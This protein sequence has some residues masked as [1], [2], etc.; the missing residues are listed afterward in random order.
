MASPADTREK[1]EGED[2]PYNSPT[3]KLNMS[4][5]VDAPVGAMWV[6]TYLCVAGRVLTVVQVDFPE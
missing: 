1:V 5:K 2:S 4:I 3:F 6:Y